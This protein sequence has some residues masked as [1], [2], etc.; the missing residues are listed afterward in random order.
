MLYI[1]NFECDFRTEKKGNGRILLSLIL[2][3]IKKTYFK[4]ENV[5]VSL[6]ACAKTRIDETGREIVSDN[7]KLIKYYKKLGFR[8]ITK[9]DD[10]MVGRLS[11]I[12]T[13]C[14]SFPGGRTSRK[15]RPITQSN[16]IS[17]NRKKNILLNY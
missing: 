16:K 17:R 8:L 10:I 9:D 2:D 5:M 4:S 6:I 12:L 15:K 13:N 3:H 14:K 1:S 7:A 11:L